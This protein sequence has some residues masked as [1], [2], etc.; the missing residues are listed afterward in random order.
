MLEIL[1]YIAGTLTIVSFV[2]Q[3]VKTLRTKDTKG[4][5]WLM[6]ILLVLSAIAWIGYGIEL[7]SLPMLITNAVVI[8]CAGLILLCKYKQRPPKPPKPREIRKG[9]MHKSEGMM[10]ID[11]RKKR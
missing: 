6:W 10:V 5:S 9:H 7:E 1:G 4:L 11:F 8:V 2:P 3:V